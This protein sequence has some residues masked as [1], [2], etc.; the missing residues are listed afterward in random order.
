MRIIGKWDIGKRRP[1]CVRTGAE[2]WNARNNCYKS[3]GKYGVI[4]KIIHK[5]SKHSMQF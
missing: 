4:I 2:T 5:S 1:H 3:L